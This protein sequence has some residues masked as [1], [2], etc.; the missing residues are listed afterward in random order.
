MGS[1]GMQYHVRYVL[2]C[3]VPYYVLAAKGITTIPVPALRA[4]WIFGIVLFSCFALRANYFR[5]YK[6]DYRDAL[7]HLASAQQPGDCMVISPDPKSDLPS[8]EWAVYVPSRTPPRVIPP[9]AIQS[10]AGNC[11]RVWFL[12]G[13]ILPSDADQLRQFE[14][15]LPT[16]FTETEERHYFWVST[17]LFTRQP[18]P[19]T[20]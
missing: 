17:T 19:G 14:R 20:F 3:T 18:N 7:L 5:P 2:F 1:L 4:V 10:D 6:E 9:D 11:D 15:K 12:A 16:S 8:R 13:Q